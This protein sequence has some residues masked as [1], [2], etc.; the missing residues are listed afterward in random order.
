MFEYAPSTRAHER[1]A[2]ARRRSAE[3]TLRL[4]RENNRPKSGRP[5]LPLSLKQAVVRRF[6]MVH[7]SFFKIFSFTSN[8]FHAKAVRLSQAHYALAVR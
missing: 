5:M 1:S 8:R 3:G 6:F 7:L 2:M 4:E